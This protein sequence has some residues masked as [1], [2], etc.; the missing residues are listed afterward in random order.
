MNT[1]PRRE[2][3]REWGFQVMFQAQ[4][5]NELLAFSGPNG[6][7]SYGDAFAARSAASVVETQLNHSAWKIPGQ[8]A[9]QK[10]WTGLPNALSI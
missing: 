10:P 4:S 8:P 3:L 2:K 1:D 9:Q 6:W 5:V 7:L